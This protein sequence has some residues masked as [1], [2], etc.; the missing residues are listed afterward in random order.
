ME[1]V[2]ESSQV[3]FDEAGHDN[4]DAVQQLLENDPE[5]VRARDFYERTPLHLAASRDALRCVKF[6][7]DKG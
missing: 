1:K 4:L 3:V 6:L 5:L 7:L 2:S